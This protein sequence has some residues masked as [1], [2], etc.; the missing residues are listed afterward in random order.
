[1]GISFSFFVDSNHASNNSVISVPSWH[2]C[3]F[4]SPRRRQPPW[5]FRHLLAKSVLPCTSPLANSTPTAFLPNLQSFC[6]F[7]A[8]A[9]SVSVVPFS[10]PF[11]PFWWHWIESWPSKLHSVRSQ[12]PLHSPTSSFCCTVWSDRHPQPWPSVSHWNLDQTHYHRCWTSE[13]YSS[14]LLTD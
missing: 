10:S 5:G 8:S 14:T 11:S 7:L 9:H 1:M 4:W 2:V 12:H 13:L 3:L 6:T